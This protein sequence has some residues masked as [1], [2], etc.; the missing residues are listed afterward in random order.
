MDK[1]GEILHGDAGRITYKLGKEYTLNE[2]CTWVI[3]AK[4]L[5]TVSVKLV[6]DGF[7][8]CCDG[9]QINRINPDG[10]LDLDAMFM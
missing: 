6:S 5:S 9:L 1:C 8:S 3:R 2:R 4:S 7:E 10:H